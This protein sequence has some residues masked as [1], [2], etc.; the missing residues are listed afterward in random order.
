MEPKRTGAIRGQPHRTLLTLTEFPAI[1]FGHQRIG[2]SIRLTLLHTADEVNTTDNV[3]PLISAAKLNRAA[4]GAEQM[5]EVIGLQNHVTEF[6]V[7]DALL[8]LFQAALHRIA[9]DH[10]IDTEM[11]ANIT[12]HIKVTKGAQPLTIVNHRC[13]AG[14]LL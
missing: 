9:H 4:H 1:S 2:N 3:S 12:Q 10:L 7:A 6:G 5:H 8:A 14:A 11:L 13:G